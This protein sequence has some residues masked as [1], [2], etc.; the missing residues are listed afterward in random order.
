[1]P[2]GGPLSV[3]GADC[4][5]GFDGFGALLEGAADGDSVGAGAAMFAGGMTA[6]TAAAMTMMDGRYSPLSVMNICSGRG[7]AWCVSISIS[8]AVCGTYGRDCRQMA[9]RTEL[10]DFK[11]AASCARF[12]NGLGRHHN[13]PRQTARIVVGKS[14]KEWMIIA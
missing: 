12:L 1:M 3:P 4:I 9:A 13:D 7:T 8:Q 14:C 2:D 6:A 11:H 5:A 10:P